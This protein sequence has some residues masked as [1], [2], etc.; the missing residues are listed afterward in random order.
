MQTY[1]KKDLKRMYDY[2]QEVARQARTRFLAQKI[3]KEVLESASKGFTKRE[4]D[5]IPENIVDDLIFILRGSFPDSNF[6]KG[7]KED[8]LKTRQIAFIIIDWT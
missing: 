8:I 1:T 4:F 7:I 3:H 2:S 6:E 5:E